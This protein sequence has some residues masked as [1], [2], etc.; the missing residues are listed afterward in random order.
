MENEAS[1]SS[2]VL[3]ASLSYTVRV[4]VPVEGGIKSTPQRYPANVLIC[5]EAVLDPLEVDFKDISILF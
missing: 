4:A 5:D 3:P 2:D 1:T